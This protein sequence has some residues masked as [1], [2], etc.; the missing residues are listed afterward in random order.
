MSCIKKFFT[1][2]HIFSRFVCLYIQYRGMPDDCKALIFFKNGLQWKVKEPLHAHHRKLMKRNECICF[3]MSRLLILIYWHADI[4]FH[5]SSIS[6]PHSAFQNFP[7]LL[8]SLAKHTLQGILL[9]YQ[10]LSKNISANA[11]VAPPR[12]T[13]AHLLNLRDTTFSIA[14]VYW[15]MSEH[16]DTFGRAPLL[17]PPIGGDSCFSLCEQN[18]SNRM[19]GCDKGPVIIK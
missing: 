18:Y 15:C 19:N 16:T 8:F 6:M 4:F 11:D 7:C 10:H 3:P 13:A 12:L 14:H 1:F 9:L 17:P 2:Q 5:L